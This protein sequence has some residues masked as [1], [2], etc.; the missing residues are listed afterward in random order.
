MLNELEE[1]GLGRAEEALK[2]ANAVEDHA[3]EKEKGD[4][5]V[6]AQKDAED[7]SVPQE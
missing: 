1:T 5:D 2:A 4:K 7:R 6:K 3:E